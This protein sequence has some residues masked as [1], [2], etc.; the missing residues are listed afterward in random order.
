MDT[1]TLAAAT[2]APALRPPSARLVSKAGAKAAAATVAAAAAAASPAAAAGCATDS[3]SLSEEEDE[4]LLQR[5]RRRSHAAAEPGPASERYVW[6]LQQHVLLVTPEQL[7]RVLAGA[8]VGHWRRWRRWWAGRS[9]PSTRT[10]PPDTSS[11]SRHSRYEQPV[12]PDPATTNQLADITAHVATSC[13]RYDCGRRAD[14]MLLCCSGGA[15]MTQTPARSALSPRTLSSAMKALQQKPH[16][17]WT[18]TS[19]RGTRGTR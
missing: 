12:R 11:T 3:D 16:A 15:S 18:G 9:W 13:G 5:E 7:T 17:F 14:W 6:L 8:G 10:P 19:G 4:E 1:T 2:T